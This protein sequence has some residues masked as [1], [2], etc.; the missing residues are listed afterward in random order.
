MTVPLD[1]EKEYPGE[2][3]VKN[4]RTGQTKPEGLKTV[5]MPCLCIIL[6]MLVS[7]TRQ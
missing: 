5:S 1:F 2:S 3:M 4:R 7:K 6:L